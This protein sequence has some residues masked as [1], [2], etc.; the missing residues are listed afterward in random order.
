MTRMGYRLDPKD[1]RRRRTVDERLGERIARLRKQRGLTQAELS[2]AAGLS[3]TTITKTEQGSRHSVSMS[4]LNALARVF[5]V[6]T[7]DL[8]SS[9]VSM[10]R[11]DN[12][13]T[14][15]LIALRRVLVPVP[16]L[17]PNIEPPS[18]VDLRRDLIDLTEL[19]QAN[20]YD[21]ALS[22]IPHLL[23]SSDAAAD[24]GDPKAVKLQARSYLMAA[25]ILLQYRR[26]DLS[27]EASRRAM[28]A[29]QTAGDPLLAASGADTVA[30]VFQRQAR[31]E[32]A[33]EQRESWLN[34]SSPPETPPKSS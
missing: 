21:K 12:G 15:D 3:L 6:R 22:G 16:G 2:A 31:L 4:T 10:D 11:D 24:S 9:P 34:E 29:A 14:A 28:V 30:W 32:D 13:D 33:E 27:Y 23:L 19:Y 26:E 20:H 25:L 5:E 8:L 1:F 17:G 7:S 18:L